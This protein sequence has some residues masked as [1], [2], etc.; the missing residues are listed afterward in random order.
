MRLFLAMRRHSIRAILLISLVALGVTSPGCTSPRL[1]R[2][3]GDIPV[4][5]SYS[6]SNLYSVGRLPE[7]LRRVA[8]LPLFCEQL[9]RSDR[10]RLDD[11]IRLQLLQAGRFEL[12]PVSSV[13]LE[14]AIGV[15]QL[16]SQLA[17]PVDLLQ[18][19]RNELQVE[20]VFQL[21]L[22]E[23][24]PY[25]P[26]RVGVRA[27]LFDVAQGTKLWAVDEV[28]GSDQASVIVAARK[29][30]GEQAQQRYPYGDSYAALRGPMHFSRFVLSRL[31]Q[32]LPSAAR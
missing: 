20:A 11:Q 22:T 16:S 29:Y 7:G 17:V 5:L 32:T 21:D 13:Q 8:V 9:D 12:V 18:Y 4:G 3:V 24:R 10:E 30:A 27:R 19:L 1:E 31:L 14:R 28:L 15:H 26:Y 25:R 2:A 6:P 23:Y